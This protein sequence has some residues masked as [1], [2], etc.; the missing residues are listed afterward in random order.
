MD[1][2]ELS[3]LFLYLENLYY[4]SLSFYDKYLAIKYIKSFISFYYKDNIDSFLEDLKIG[5]LGFVESEFIL[6]IR[7]ELI[8][9]DYYDIKEL[10]DELS[11]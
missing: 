9:F 8:S 3:Q 11:E 4:D 2:L 10:Y 5:D 1:K 6:S 7:E